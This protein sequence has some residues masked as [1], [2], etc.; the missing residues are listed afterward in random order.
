LQDA[1]L[2]H[3]D[4]KSWNLLVRDGR[5]A[6]VLDWEFAFA[7]P[8]LNDIGIFLRYS[9]RQPPAFEERFVRGYLAAG[10]QLPPDWRRL[11]RL[12]D[13]ISLCWFLEQPVEDLVKIRDVT[14]LIERTIE[15]FSP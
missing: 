9:E 14:P 12:Q 5:I 3:A 7:G 6:A 8:R 13:L 4:Y 2:Q 15:L 11:A 10:G 1:R